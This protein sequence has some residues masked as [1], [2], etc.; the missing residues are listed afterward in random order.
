LIAALSAIVIITT[1]GTEE[2]AKRI[3]NEL[4]SR[5]QA[6]CVNILPIARSV[7]RWQGKVCEDSEFLLVVKT[8]EHEFQ[9][10]QETIQELHQYE[11]PEILCFN[12]RKGSQ[13][14]LDWIADSVGEGKV[15]GNGAWPP[16]DS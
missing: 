2:Q 16:G 9:A 13:N 11:V 14:F 4:V 5:R 8:L 7:Y 1:V 3:S 15:A 12:V 10:V 6:A